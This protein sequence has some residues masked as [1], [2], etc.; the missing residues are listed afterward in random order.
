MFPH[1]MAE[2]VA[3]FVK[4]R[5]EHS[6]SQWLAL[7]LLACPECSELFHRR[8]PTRG[9][10]RLSEVLGMVKPASGWPTE[11]ARCALDIA[12]NDP[13]WALWDSLRSLPPG[14]R[15]L[16]VRNLPQS[17]RTP[18]LAMAILRDSRQLWH[19][20]AREAGDLA[21]L[22]VQLVLR[23]Q[24]DHYPWPTLLNDLA[25]EGL[26]YM[27]NAQRIQG[28]LAHAQEKLQGALRVFLEGGSQDV[29]LLA[30]FLWL[31]AKVHRDA[32]D[33]SLARK[34]YDLAEACFEAVDDQ[35]WLGILELDKANLLAEQ[36]E[37]ELCAQ[38]LQNLIEAERFAYMPHLAQLSAI[39]SL[40][41]E[42]CYLGR[43][44]EARKLV[45]EVE[46]LVGVVGGQLNHLKV[47]WLK[48]RVAAGSRRHRTAEFL[49]RELRDRWVEL[50]HSMDAALV[51]LELAELYL[52]WGRPEE[53]R[54]QAMVVVEVCRSLEGMR[55]E[56]LEA[57]ATL[58]RAEEDCLKRALV[59][60]RTL[61]DPPRSP[62]RTRLPK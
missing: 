43:F 49:Y 54:D 40:A 8:Y 35:E 27:G 47:R 58:A 39:H 38:C 59:S 11:I 23:L 16:R 42:L 14:E 36:G 4:G 56:E 57:I 5:V 50:E 22:A 18:G 41:F 48:A 62:T 15:G 32:E 1:L 52:A 17:Q 12:D 26:A 53:A 19:E 37:R 29:R 51:T 24:A 61:L 13:G 21:V 33:Y 6:R 10:E 3:A 60:L 30:N 46:R 25:A 45:P 28:Q 20:S 9:D 31:W 34:L 2:E 44:F 7:H 55:R